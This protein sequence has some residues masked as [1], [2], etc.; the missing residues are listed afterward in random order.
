MTLWRI[1]TQYKDFHTGNRE[2]LWIDSN[3]CLRNPMWI[4]HFLGINW[5]VTARSWGKVMF[6]HLSIILFTGEGAP[7]STSECASWMHLPACTPGWTPP[8]DASAPSDAPLDALPSGCIP[9]MHHHQWI[10][11][12]PPPGDAP[13]TSGCT[14]PHAH[15]H[16]KNDRQSNGERNASY[17]NVYLL[18]EFPP[19]LGKTQLSCA[20]RDE[21]VI[22]HSVVTSLLII[23]GQDIA[24]YEIIPYYRATIDMIGVTSNLHFRTHPEFLMILLN[25]WLTVMFMCYNQYQETRAGIL[26]I[27]AYL[28]ESMFKAHYRYWLC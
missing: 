7:W 12:F 5:I 22:F 9:W 13:P 21:K 16:Q 11:P 6:L 23:L 26:N 18:T 14:P 1:T 27:A 4:H 2:D 8:L 24:I 17:C 25:S 19:H 28:L 15:P 20:F 3:S 10:N